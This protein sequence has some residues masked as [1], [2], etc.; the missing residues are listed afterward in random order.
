MVNDNISDALT[1][2]RNALAVKH[3]IVEIPATKAVKKIVEVMRREGFI[4][5]FHEIQNGVASFLSITLKYKGKNRSSIINKLKRISRP[6]LRIYSRNKELPK[7]L[8]GA[9]IAIV[10]TSQGIMTNKEAKQKGV[11]GEILCYIW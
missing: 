7:I 5:D 9:G 10:S 4:E 8:G 3:Q 1:R 2:I 6:G 11:G